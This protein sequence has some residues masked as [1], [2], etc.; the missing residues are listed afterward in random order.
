MSGRDRDLAPR[1][2]F[3]TGSGD[4]YSLTCN[5]YRGAHSPG[6]TAGGPEAGHSMYLVPTLRMRQA[7]PQLAP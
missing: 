5:G 4:H 7:I 1:R 2:S 6:D 3:Q